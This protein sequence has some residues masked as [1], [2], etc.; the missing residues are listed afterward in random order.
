ML[1]VIRAGSVM[2]V[3]AVGARIPA[4]AA[5]SVTAEGAA[6]LPVFEAAGAVC[7]G[8]VALFGSA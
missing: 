5:R 3:K 7:S 8:G 6:A 1:G 4:I 2:P